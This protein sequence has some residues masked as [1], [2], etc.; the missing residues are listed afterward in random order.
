MN[1]S[2]I[3]LSIII[4]TYNRIQYLPKCINNCKQQ[5]LS[6][7]R[8]EVIVVDNNSTDDTKS[9]CLD[10][11]EKNPDLN[12]IY[13]NESNQGHTWARNKGID[14][15]KGSILSFLDDDAFPNSEYAERIIHFFSGHPHVIGIGGKII[16]IYEDDVAPQ[17]MSSYLLTLV[18]AIDLGNKNIPFT[19]SKFPIGANMAF[20][21]SA[22]EKVGKFN[23]NLGRKGN[24]LEGGDE[25]DLAIRLKKSGETLMYVHDVLVDHIIP[26]KRIQI[27]YIR[28]LGIGVGKSEKKRLRK[29][30]FIEKPKKVLSELIKIA[31][32]LILAIYF[33]LQLKPAKANMLIKF[34]F[35]VIQGYFS[36]II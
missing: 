2:R 31:A 3:E 20:R 4:C 7:T 35:W 22:F 13:V 28:D 21:Q 27:P 9:F 30:L 29:E 24:E 8:Y 36:K 5:S 32:T 25:K 10:F 17:W 15:S 18:S 1:D 23:V 12:F 14:I 34:R 6:K 16:P 26:S 11:K 33:Y 19:G